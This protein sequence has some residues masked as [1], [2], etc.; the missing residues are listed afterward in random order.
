MNF[1]EPFLPSLRRIFVAAFA[2]GV[3]GLHLRRKP[4][5]L[6]NAVVAR[7]APVAVVAAVAHLHVGLL[8]QTLL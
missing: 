5:E 7:R 3:D 4:R 8:V 6:V 1:P 2:V